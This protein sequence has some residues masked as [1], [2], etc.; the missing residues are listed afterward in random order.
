M[1]VLLVLLIQIQLYGCTTTEVV[2]EYVPVQK[3]PLNLKYPNSPWVK[4]MHFKAIRY[5][6]DNLICLTE[7]NYKTL[8]LNSKSVLNYI[9]IQDDVIQKYKEYYEFRD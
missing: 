8:I 7:D 5:Q 4:D 6:E 9:L 1:R 2:V 3:E